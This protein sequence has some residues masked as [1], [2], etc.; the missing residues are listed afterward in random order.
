MKT[1]VLGASENKQRYS[2][3][4]INMLKEYQHEV[5]AIGNR[6]GEVSGV[7]FDKEKKD[8]KDVDTVTLYLGP[9]NQASFRKYIDSL[10]PRRVIF[11][12]GT[13]NPEWMRHL[14][15]NGIATEVACTLVLLR[16][17]QY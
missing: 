7:K 12:P 1:L 13:E 17:H 9:Q 10:R 5:V 6:E 8:F 15:E 14:Q 2:N 3:I 11:N 16:T 4:A